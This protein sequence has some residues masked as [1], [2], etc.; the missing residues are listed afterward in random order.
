MLLWLGPLGL[1]LKDASRAARQRG[2]HGGAVQ[3]LDDDNPQLDI[4]A[5][6][7]NAGSRRAAARIAGC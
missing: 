2:Q 1:A 6:A 5:N 7:A 4:P 3:L